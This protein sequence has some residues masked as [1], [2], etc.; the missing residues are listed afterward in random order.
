MT[1]CTVKLDP[2]ARQSRYK[3]LLFFKIQYIPRGS[4]QFNQDECDA[5]M[6]V[7]YDTVY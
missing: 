6:P 2:S 1:V 4:P 3:Q 5:Y 7:H